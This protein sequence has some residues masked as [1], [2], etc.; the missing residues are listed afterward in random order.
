MIIFVADEGMAAAA[1]HGRAGNV[2]RDIEQVRVFCVTIL[3]FLVCF[4]EDK[5]FGVSSL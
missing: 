3:L 4:V 1:D 2:E 5:E